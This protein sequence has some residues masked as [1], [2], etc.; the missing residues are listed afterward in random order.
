SLITS[1][2]STPQSWMFEEFGVPLSLSYNPNL[3]MTSLD[4]HSLFSRATNIYAECLTHARF[5]AGRWMIDELFK[6]KFGADY[7]GVQEISSHAAFTLINTEPL[8][9]FA[10]PTLNRVIP[11]GG[12]G[13]RSPKP[14]N[15]YWNEVL[16][17]RN[18][19]ILLSFGSVAKSVFLPPVIKQSILSTIG[20]FPDA[21]FIWKYEEPEDDFG[22]A[23]SSRSSAISHEM[24]E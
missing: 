16:S 12:I 2:G 17:R 10:V 4:V 22:T 24:R 18:R 13:V 1:S 20:S 14:L 3:Y 8:L 21:T 6:E 23:F 15:E 19:T 11:I 7:P 5:Y 9:D